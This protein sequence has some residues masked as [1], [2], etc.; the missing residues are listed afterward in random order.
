MGELILFGH[1]NHCA[2]KAW[3]ITRSRM[4]AQSQQPPWLHDHT[5]LMVTRSQESI[6]WY[7]RKVNIISKTACSRWQNKQKTMR[8][9]LI[10]DRCVPRWWRRVLS[11]DVFCSWCA[12]YVGFFSGRWDWDIQEEVALSEWNGGGDGFVWDSEEEF[13]VVGQV[14]KKRSLDQWGHETWWFFMTG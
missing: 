12:G 3:H 6:S 11:G 8:L 14:G 5:S 10:M 2:T 7:I 9:E 4:I 13:M 1:D